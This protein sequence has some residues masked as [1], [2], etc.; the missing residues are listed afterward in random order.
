[1]GESEVANG[2]RVNVFYIDGV[3]LFKHYFDG[4]EVFNRV[5]QYYNNHQYRF[6]VPENDFVELKEFLSENGYDL[7]VVDEVEEFAV[8]VKK[9]TAHPDNIFKQ[10]IIQRSVDGYNCFLMN[11][12]KAV[13]K[14][15]KGGAIP[16]PET[17][18]ESPF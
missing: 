13:A 16:L 4:E 1:M 15:R 5:R 7:V 14:A 18:L 2:E 10:S 8:I 6:E 3:F 9:Y 12:K 11:T 17:K